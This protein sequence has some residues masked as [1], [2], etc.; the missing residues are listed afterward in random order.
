MLSLQEVCAES[1]DAI[2]IEP[3]VIR[4]TGRNRQTQ[5]LITGH[6]KD[7]T[8]DDL[9]S[10]ATLSIQDQSVATLSNSL[11]LGQTEGTTNLTVQLDSFQQSIP[12]HVAGYQNYP[13]VNFEVDI[14]PLLTKLN[15]NVVDVMEDRGAKTVSS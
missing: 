13:P 3:E 8:L 9:T 10:Q 14:I 15:C 2:T 5:L 7:G 1:Y 6:R 12:I 4:I 11:V